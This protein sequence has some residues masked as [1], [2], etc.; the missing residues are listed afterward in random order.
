MKAVDKK[1]GEETTSPWSSYTGGLWCQRQDEIKKAT[2]I[3]LTGARTFTF[4]V[5][6]MD[7]DGFNMCHGRRRHTP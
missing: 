6:G 2:D 5:P 4:A 7:G 1:N 3:T